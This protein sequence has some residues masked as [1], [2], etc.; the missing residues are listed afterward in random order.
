MLISIGLNVNV[1][2]SDKTL[3]ARTITAVTILANVQYIVFTF[4]SKPNLDIACHIIMK[5]AQI[6]IRPF[7]PMTTDRTALLTEI[8][9]L[10]D[11]AFKKL[12]LAVLG[13]W[14]PA[15]SPPPVRWIAGPPP[16]RVFTVKRKLDLPD[17]T[18]EPHTLLPKK[19]KIAHPP[20]AY[21]DL[22][23]EE[24]RLICERHL[25]QRA[26]GYQTTNPDTKERCWRAMRL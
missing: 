25:R 14:P 15:S 26:L 8:Y 13:S 18:A 21:A 20:K 11:E 6:S 3:N 19:A 24:R 22:T 10:S 1:V 7:H 17:P 2:R 5:V 16:V 23:E 4:A 12:L 9:K